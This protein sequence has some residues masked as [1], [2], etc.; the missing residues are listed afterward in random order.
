[1]AFRY[2]N[3]FR[4]AFAQAVSAKPADRRAL[5]ERILP[6]AEGGKRR[7]RL[8]SFA[9]RDAAPGAIVAAWLGDQITAEEADDL[10][11]QV[12]DALEADLLWTHPDDHPLKESLRAWREAAQGKR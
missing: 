9:D 3:K 1:M 12:R 8:R 7:L 4:R 2:G 5:I 11:R 10:L 6:P